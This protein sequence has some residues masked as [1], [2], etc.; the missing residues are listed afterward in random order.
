MASETQLNVF[1]SSSDFSVAEYLNQATSLGDGE[2]NI[3][4]IN[5]TPNESDN[6]AE[7][8]ILAELALHL[9]VQTQSCHDE[10]GRIGAELRAILPRCAA[11]LGRLHSGIEG[12][13]DDSASLLGSHLQASLS[14]IPENDGNGDINDGKKKDGGDEKDRA[15][16]EV[17]N[18]SGDKENVA[19]TQDI[20]TA[21]SS[22]TNQN[23]A[24]GM[25]PLETL[26]TL[27]TLHAL[28][29]NLSTTKQILTAASTYNSTLT[30][31]SSHMTP[32][33]IHQAVSSLST[34]EQGARAL[35]GMPGKSQR[36]DE[37]SH[38]RNQILT[39]LKPILL[40]ALNKMESRLGPLQTCVGMYQSLNKMENLMEEYVKSR[41]SAIHKLWFEFRKREMERK[42]LDKTHELEFYSDD[43]EDAEDE[44]A[45]EL[46]GD[47]QDDAR[48]LHDPPV[49]ANSNVEDPARAFG[50]W[51]PTWY[52]A[53]LILLSEE[54][55]RAHAVFGANLAPE[56]IVKVL[57]E[58]FRP[59]LSSFKTRLNA[60][61]PAVGKAVAARVSA[62]ASSFD[63]V[64]R[65]YEATLQ[66]LS[67]AYEHMVD[68]DSMDYDSMDYDGDD[69]N[70]NAAND[71]DNMKASKNSSSDDPA[72]SVE[73]SVLTRTKT[74]V[75]LHMM[76]RSV[77]ISITSPF[78]PY[79]TNFA[80]LEMMHSDT[81]ARMVS[82]DMHNAVSGRVTNLSS[83]QDSVER[84][85]GL[86]PFM[87][88]L[89]QAAIARF[90][91]VNG[92]FGAPKALGTV[93]NVLS[94]HIEELSMSFHTLSSNATS[95]N[96]SMEGFD[97]QQV[98][99]AL[100]ALKIAGV[101]R[102]ELNM[103]SNKT[104]QRLSI[105][106]GRM[107]TTIDQEAA[108]THA[109][110][111][112]VTNADIVPESLS[113]AD[114]ESLLAT[115]VCAEVKDKEGTA[116]KAPSVQE[117]KRLANDNK[118]IGEVVA[119]FP[120]SVNNTVRL[121]QSCQ[122]FVFDI[123]AHIPFKNIDL[124]PSLPIWGQEE[125]MWSS[126]AADSYGTLPQSYITQV[127]EHMLAL[128]QA[129]EP[130][131]SDEDSLHLANLVM[132]GVD[133]VA[134]RSWRDF[135]N[136]IH[137]IDLDE[138]EFIST[139]KKGNR[140]KDLVLGHVH[141][142]FEE[143]DDYG[144]DYGDDEDGDSSAANEFCNEWLDAVCSSV[145]GKLLERTMRIQKLSRKGCEHLTVDYNYIVNV[146][147]AL[148]VSGHPH[149][150]LSHVAEL[151]SMD[152]ESL[153][154]R[155]VESADDEFGLLKTEV[156]IAQMRG[157]PTN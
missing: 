13:K 138:N 57:N 156:R 105:M 118:N 126:T 114:I 90:E 58:C 55:R 115:F 6:E 83:L 63:A 129:L 42:E 40:H 29:Q 148:G 84:L 11:D 79:Q 132:E 147:S 73:Q 39:L 94:R 9:Q 15:V 75:Q 81:A 70:N 149:P 82:S 3:G 139:L 145:T 50:E 68:F 17:S 37:I 125:S 110:V 124:M 5:A 130:F 112:S 122:S 77:F 102:R 154:A 95:D 85:A 41:P 60:I 26:E 62:S 61:C 56:I 28:Q 22:R 66:F 69:H 30:T 128:V 133:H 74:P 106:V 98:Q 71:D 31:L 93:D 78:S 20:I 1:L 21:S 127:G 88:P 150:L 151:S 104:K 116:E 32:S 136:A 123:C 44:D 72:G 59:I 144:D 67:V 24:T 111:N 135:A 12:M 34:L 65:A 76:A 117:V 27:S 108:L 47:T 92:G 143:G 43:E 10:I 146:L 48:K 16:T 134:D 7:Q 8:R 109:V 80:D 45:N 89:V 100:E 18:I 53:V 155:I 142:S 25:T 101:I 86:A 113:P 96:E 33:T 46:G 91:S 19:P 49:H 137:Y 99:S 36:N 107:A 64:C 23:N 141:N 38:I 157:I 103:F 35:V 87:F 97:E 131:A 2:T 121:V 52:E 153:Q 152:S 51:L 140:L 120:K 4:D 54:R 14:H 119:L